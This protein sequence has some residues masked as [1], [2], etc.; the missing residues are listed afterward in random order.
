MLVNKRIVSKA[1]LDRTLDNTPT[2]VI[3]KESTTTLATSFNGTDTKLRFFTGIR[4]PI[5]FF[6][7]VSSK[8]YVYK[9]ILR[10]VS[11]DGIKEEL[12]ASLQDLE[13]GYKDKFIGSI[14]ESLQVNDEDLD[15]LLLTT[16]YL[17]S[18]TM[19]EGKWQLTGPTGKEHVEISA[20]EVVG[21][22]V[23]GLPN[24]PI[25]NN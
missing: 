16:Y 20:Y 17:Q 12:F 22:G 9:D 3:E 14:K 10:L 2:K 8:L 18:P 19:Y 21:F 15:S 1:E 23:D 5:T 6:K 7:V 24:L 25:K 13:D 11:L 4:Y